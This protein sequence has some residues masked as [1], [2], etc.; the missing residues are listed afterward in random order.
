MKEVAEQAGVSWE[1][2]K[3]RLGELEDNDYVEGED[4]GNSI[5]WWIM[6]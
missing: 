5:Q 6:E 2:A 3:D 4:Q 1:T